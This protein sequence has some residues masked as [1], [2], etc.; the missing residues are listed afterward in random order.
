MLLLASIPIVLAERKG[1]GEPSDEATAG[2]RKKRRPDHFGPCRRSCRIR[3][4]T[5]AAVSLQSGSTWNGAHGRWMVPPPDDLDT[6]LRLHARLLRSAPTSR[7]LD[8]TGLLVSCRFQ[9]WT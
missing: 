8:L 9:I 3:D 6:T 5:C 2:P 4:T 1:W 7:P